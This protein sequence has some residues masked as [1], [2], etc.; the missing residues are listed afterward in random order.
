M[1]AINMNVDRSQTTDDATYQP[2][3]KI[4]STNYRVQPNVDVYPKE[5]KMLIIALNH[6]L[7]STV[8]S[9]SFSIPMTWLSLAGLTVV[10]NKTT[11]VVIF[12]LT[13]EKNYNL[14]KKQFSQILNIPNVEP[15]YEVTNE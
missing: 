9:S 4:Q 7:L 14:S 13:N 8:M 3:L 5:L 11:K 1:T 12:Q 6:S 15:F 10:F 2:L